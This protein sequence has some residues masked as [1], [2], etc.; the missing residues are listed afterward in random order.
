MF[1]LASVPFGENDTF[2]APLTLL[3]LKAGTPPSMSGAA[4]LLSALLVTGTVICTGISGLL[5]VW[6]GSRQLSAHPT[7]SPTMKQ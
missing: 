5:Y 1:E 7:S 4:T 3:Q 6:D 2:P